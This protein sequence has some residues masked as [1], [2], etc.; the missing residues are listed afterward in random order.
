MVEEAIKWE[1]AAAAA[2]VEKDV[3]EIVAG[4]G[5]GPENNQEGPPPPVQISIDVPRQRNSRLG[6]RF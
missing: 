4:D 6:G 2:L 5:P 1:A 3:A